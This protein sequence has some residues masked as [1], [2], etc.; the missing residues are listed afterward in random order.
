MTVIDI[1][2]SIQE[3]KV[4]KG[5]SVSAG[6][7]KG[8]AHVIC[9]KEQEQIPHYIVSKDQKEA[10]WNRF[11]EAAKKTREYL[12]SSLD[13]TNEEQTAIFDTYIMMLT[14]PQF[15]AE[16]KEAYFTQD[17]NIEAV[18]HAK[19]KEYSD[20]LR[21]VNDAYLSERAEDI[22]DV[23]GKVM[24]N[25]LGRKTLQFSE[26]PMGSVIS[27][28]YLNP[29][30]AL[31]L[32]KVQPAALILQEG[33]TG[34]HLAIL[35]RSYEIPAIFAVQEGMESIKDGDSVIVDAESAHVF[36][37]PDA[38]TEKEYEEK[39]EV[40]SKKREQLKTYRSK[41]AKTKDG[42]S[43]TLLANIG[44]SEEVENALKEGAQGIGLFRTEFMFMECGSFLGEEEQFLEY[45]RVLV[46][47]Q[48]KPVVI[49]TLDSGGDKL[50]PTEGETIDHGSNPLLGWRAI[51]FC[52]SR[53]DIFKIQ[54]RALFRASVFG[55]LQIM[56]PLITT[57]DEVKETEKIVE[58]VKEELRSE[59]IPFDDSV[60]VG[61]MIETA[62]A[63]V[64]A[65]HL[66]KK[67]GFFS[68]G[69]NDLTQYTLAVDREK[70][71]VSHMFDECNPAI[72]RL[73]RHTVREGKK[74][75][76]SVSVCGEFASKPEGVIILA[77]MG[78][79]NL[80]MSASSLCSVKELLSTL[81][82]EQIEEIE[83]KVFTL[84]PDVKVK[85]FI[86][87]EIE[88]QQNGS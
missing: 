45:K 50:V 11:K 4:L 59:N 44:S 24:D 13:K 51:R 48:G 2:G 28:V 72:L 61:I 5:L 64:M 36:V 82:L 14:D 73:I 42:E 62:S 71:E 29:S 70:V 84:S 37:L 69:T 87:K 47:M 15:L 56:I 60:L 52:L 68:L 40:Y 8:K 66:A 55:N 23:F 41:E 85:E 17:I 10:G 9:Q 31:L 1:E 18:L 7:G 19:T 25:L 86:L 83:K 57:Y 58:E 22:D 16:L 39:I 3:M 77:G 43:F 35:A 53:P 12:E 75:G 33:G 63:V 78:V 38:A 21:A 27:A 80:S 46:A 20:R 67:A 30:D 49:R 65:D 88:R 74:A 34:S 76:I 6:I 79:R 26:I 54:L 32:Y 81:T